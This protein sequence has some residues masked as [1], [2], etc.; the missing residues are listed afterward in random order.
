M[1]VRRRLGQAA[2]L[3]I[4]A[5]GGAL[6]W[7]DVP[8]EPTA[9]ERALITSK[10]QSAGIA[11]PPSHPQHYA[12]QLQRIRQVQDMVL[13][14][15]PAMMPIPLGQSREPEALFAAKSGHCADRSRAI[16]KILRLEGFTLRHVFL[17][18]R[19]EGE[20]YW[21]PL[22]VAGRD[23]HAV[24]EVLTEKG[25][26]IVDSN[27]RWLTLDKT[28][29]PVSATQLE[30]KTHTNAEWAEFAPNEIYFTKVIAV[31]GLYARH[32]QFYPPYDA[33]P[34]INLSELAQNF[35]N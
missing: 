20:N 31:Y 2:L 5:L 26:L 9:T 24:T 19:R 28:G 21:Q 35:Y 14:E 25:W 11:A 15:A 12:D 34:D 6:L 32:G 7:H 23:S 27:D 4:V 22:L 29:N 8:L 16:E 3:C 13:D 10:L 17:L 18:A 30:Q 33:I 1:S